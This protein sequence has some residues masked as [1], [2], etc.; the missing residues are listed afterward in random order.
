MVLGR[1]A[2]QNK[3]GDT[4]YI[5]ERSIERSPKA[6]CKKQLYEKQHYEKTMCDTKSAYNQ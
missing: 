2:K 1:T 6:D 4:C 5:H 3:M